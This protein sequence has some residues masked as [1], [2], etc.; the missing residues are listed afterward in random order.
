MIDILIGI[1]SLIIG[2]IWFHYERTEM[3]ERKKQGDKHY[4]SGKPN[5]FLGVYIIL[6]LGL[7]LIIRAI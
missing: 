4:Y 6:A 3:L 7:A 5:A 2:S 1:C